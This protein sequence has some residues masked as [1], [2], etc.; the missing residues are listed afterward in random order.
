MLPAPPGAQ[1]AIH[2]SIPAGGVC[3]RCGNFMCN[4]CSVDGAQQNCPTCREKDATPEFPFDENASF[5]ELFNHVV[6]QF[7]RDSTMPVIGTVIYFGITMIGSVVSNLFTQVIS[8]AMGANMQDPD[9]IRDNP[10]AFVKVFAV[11]YAVS[12]VFQTLAQGVAL[13]ALYR[14]L[15]DILHGR[16]GDLARMFNH[17][18]ELPKYLGLQLLVTAMSVGVPFTLTG[19]AIAICLKVIGFDWEHPTHTRPEDVFAPVPLAIFGG[20]MLIVAV[21]SIVMMPVMIFAMPELVVS[22]CTPTEALERAFRLGSGQRLRL[23]GYSLL[24][25]I[26]IFVGVFACCIGML[27]TLPVGYM[28]LG[29]LFLSLRKNSGLPKIQL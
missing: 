5:T 18:K 7:K 8:A 29:A 2:P 24:A 21:F 27:V 17:L 11:S 23:F 19:G 1:C 22:N 6:E 26:I 13:G 9:A 25:S 3:A 10:M 16:K 12:L 14:L 28:L 15:I 4:D 20:V